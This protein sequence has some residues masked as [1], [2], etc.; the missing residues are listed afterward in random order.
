MRQAILIMGFT[1][2]FFIT[3]LIVLSINTDIVRKNELKRVVASSLKQSVEKTS[4]ADKS[5]IDSNK[6]LVAEFI[7]NLIVSLNS[8]GSIKVEV[9]GVDYRSGMLDVLVTEK[10]KY[11]N[12]REGEISVR[13]C[14]VFE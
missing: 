6:K 7:N 8:S 9:M 13:K 10:Y 2:S 12:G 5:G 14:A 3:G 11:I 4:M 1:I